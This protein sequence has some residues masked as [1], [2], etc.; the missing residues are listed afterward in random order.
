MKFR[1]I[2]VG[3]RFGKTYQSMLWTVNMSL[4]INW[5]KALGREYK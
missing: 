4:A 5:L 1:T 2:W 3:Q